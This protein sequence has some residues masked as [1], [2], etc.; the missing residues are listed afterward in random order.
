MHFLRYYFICDYI[1]FRLISKLFQLNIYFNWAYCLPDIKSLC[2]N[3]W[4]MSHPFVKQSNFSH[5]NQLDHYKISFVENVYIAAKIH[6][7][8]KWKVKIEISDE[9]WMLI[10]YVNYRTWKLLAYSFLTVATMNNTVSLI[11]MSIICI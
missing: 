7:K 1:C 11:K 4:D 2:L 3:V 6:S 5:C 8:I 10:G 9:E